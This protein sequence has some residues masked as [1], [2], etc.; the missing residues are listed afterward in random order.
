[1]WHAYY[2]NGGPPTGGAVPPATDYVDA[3]LALSPTAYWRLGDAS[4]NA[5]DSS[6]N[7]YTLTAGGTPTYGAAGWT[8]DGDDAITFDA[9]WFTLSDAAWMDVGTN[10][11]SMSWVMKRSGTPA[12][13]EAILGHDGQGSAGEWALHLTAIS[14][15]FQVRCGAAYNLNFT[16]T[17]YDD[18]LH[19]FVL[20]CDRSADATLYLDGSSVGTVTISADVA[21]DLTNTRALWMGA[22]SA[23]PSYPFVGTLDEVAFW[24]GTLLTSGNV[25]TIYGAR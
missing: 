7:G 21:T 6:G 23:T 16:G 14:T 3:V 17:V 5:T 2:S 12:A 8:T 19:H 18:V 15:R 9:D 13:A 20:T 24:N 10:D 4:G 25:S 1:M 11:W 22:R